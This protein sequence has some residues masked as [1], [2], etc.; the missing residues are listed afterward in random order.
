MIYGLVTGIII[1][2]L[3][4]LLILLGRSSSRS[5]ADNSTSKEVPRE[6]NWDGGA[7]IMIGPIPIVIAKSAKVAK[8]L[9]VLA[10]ILFL[11]MVLVYAYMR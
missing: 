9:L 4:L 6:S 5:K 2:V 3:G 1:I 11:A 8:E 7:V 10:L